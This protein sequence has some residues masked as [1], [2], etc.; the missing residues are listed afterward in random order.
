MMKRARSDAFD[1]A[2]EMDSSE[3]EEGPLVEAKRGR[4]EP[5]NYDMDKAIA[6][7]AALRSGSLREQRCEDLVH[8]ASI[9]R[10]QALRLW[11][12]AQ[13]HQHELIRSHYMRVHFE[14]LAELKILAAALAQFDS[15]L[16]LWSI[17]DNAGCATSNWAH[18][19]LGSV[20]AH[21]GLGVKLAR[22]CTTEATDVIASL[23]VDLPRDHVTRTQAHCMRC[24]R[25]ACHGEWTPTHA[26]MMPAALATYLWK[27]RRC[28][29]DHRQQW[30][31]QRTL[32]NQIR[33]KASSLDEQ[34]Q[35]MKQLEADVSIVC[36]A[37]EA[38]AACRLLSRAMPMLHLPRLPSTK[39]SVCVS[40]RGVRS[41]QWRVKG[42]LIQLLELL[43]LED[44]GT[45]QRVRGT[46][47]Q[48]ISLIRAFEAEEDA[49]SLKDVV[50]ASRWIRL[51]ELASAVCF[52]VAQKR[53][54]GPHMP[55]S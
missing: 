22:G 26:S 12:C 33:I 34:V 9:K 20:P 35:A 15:K 50:G 32:V 8:E 28:R 14:L 48:I 49:D 53:L 3:D 31:L 38:R 5:D 39:K 21:F 11:R 41:I 30:Q 25:A 55:H 1:S 44:E 42:V 29:Q 17:A 4:C 46:C 45:C 13:R 23:L 43:D 47:A 52:T 2:E 24:Q 54:E 40:Q 19:C 51:W 6:E 7:F 10:N 27:S 36:N 16:Q 18:S 37:S